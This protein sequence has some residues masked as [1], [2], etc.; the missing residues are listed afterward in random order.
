MKT[1]FFHLA[2]ILVLLSGT[3]IVL[4]EKNEVYIIQ[5]AD[6]ISP[7]TAEFIKSGLKTAEEKE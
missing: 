3:N 1:N 4:A 7:G 6:A 5:V 2:I